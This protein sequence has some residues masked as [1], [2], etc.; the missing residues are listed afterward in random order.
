[1]SP[2]FAS[3]IKKK[4]SVYIRYDGNLVTKWIMRINSIRQ[5]S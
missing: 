1:M 3:Q 2:T 4:V 5:R